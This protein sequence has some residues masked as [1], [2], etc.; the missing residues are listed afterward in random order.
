MNASDSPLETHV[1][2]LVFIGPSNDDAIGE[3]LIK[4]PFL[5]ALHLAYPGAEITWIHGEAPLRFQS[6]LEPLARGLITD[7]LPHT[8]LG[9]SWLSAFNPCRLLPGQHY[10]LI[11]DTQKNPKFSLALRRISHDQFISSTWRFALS[12]SRP[13]G[14]KFRKGT[15]S[16]CMLQLL[17]IAVGSKQDP[18]HK[19]ILPDE[20]I[21]AA[22]LALPSGQTYIGLAPGAGRTDSGKCWSLA[23]YIAVAIDQIKKG[24]PCVF[25]L[26]PDE[27]DWQKKIIREIPGAQFSPLELTAPDGSNL[28]GP[29]VTVALAGQLSVGISNCS[30]TGHMLAAGGAP[31]VSLYGPTN[32][33]KFAPYTP[34]ITIIRAQ[35]FGGSDIE[36]IPVDAVIKA[37]DGQLEK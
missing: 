30:G 8:V 20:F 35:Q 29:T 2:I 9:D 26:G 1:R 18:G 25:F 21:V 11:I 10:N 13:S 14:G 12:S 23:N 6:I 34:D 33:D 15:L 28:S 36:L 5:R 31:M 16:E 4:L 19:A 37:I 22:K 17:E 27:A 32:P 3:N 24:R 7:V